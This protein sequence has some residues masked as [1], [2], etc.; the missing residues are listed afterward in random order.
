MGRGALPFAGTKGQEG[1]A[2]GRRSKRNILLA[3]LLCAAVVLAVVIGLHTKNAAWV[4]AMYEEGE[5]LISAGSYRAAWEQLGQ[6]EAEDYRD[7]GALLLLCQAHIA[8]DEGDFSG[9]HAKMES[10]AFLY[11]SDESQEE[12]TAFTAQVDA[13]YEAYC[14]EQDRLR[15]E[16]Y[17]TK[18]RTG[19]PYVGMPESRIGDTSL[20][21]PSDNV[22]HNYECISGEQYKAN[23]YDFKVN[24]HTI[25]T[26]RCVRGE[27]IQVWDSRDQDTSVPA[28][29]PSKSTKHST[30]TDPYHVNSYDDAEDF[31]YDYYD[32]FDGYEDAEDYFNEHHQ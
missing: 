29:Q 17:E 25:F 30:D 24:G 11:Q 32:D 21:K 20:G 5:E 26:A 28:Y 2:M 7:T 15:L 3:A 1:T 14:Q 23:L 10:A 8:Y 18:I 6:I 31:Y 19:V 22:R 12:I 9:A 16:A 13:A 4:Q 27:V